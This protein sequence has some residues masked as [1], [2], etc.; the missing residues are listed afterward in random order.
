MLNR[1]ALAAG[2][3]L[4]VGEI[5]LIPVAEVCSSSFVQDDVGTFVGT[6]RAEAVVAVGPWGA[7][8]LDVHGRERPLGDLLE[9]ALGLE[10]LVL[11]AS[12]SRRERIDTASYKRGGA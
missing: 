6:K 11:E 5:T 8:A 12:S 2:E 7:I 1:R 3:P 9:E 10:E 4:C